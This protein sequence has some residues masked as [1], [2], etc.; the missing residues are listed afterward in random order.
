MTI[1]SLPAKMTKP[2]ASAKTTPVGETENKDDQQ[3]HHHQVSDGP[4][5]DVKLNGPNVASAMETLDGAA[6]AVQIGMPQVL[7]PE[8]PAMPSMPNAVHVHVD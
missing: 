4:L 3:P 8:R 7:L 2:M 1:S 6:T 5:I